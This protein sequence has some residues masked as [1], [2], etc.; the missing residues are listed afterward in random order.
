MTD[1][2]MGLARDPRRSLEKFEDEALNFW[3]EKELR[4]STPDDQSRLWDLP[5]AQSI[6]AK[7]R[8]YGGWDYPSKDFGGKSWGSD[9]RLLETFRQLRI[10]VEVYGFDKRHPAMDAIVDFVG[11]FQSKAGDI[12]GILGNQYMPYYQGAITELLIK[13]G[14]KEDSRIQASL[15]WMLS[16]RQEDGGWIVPIQAIPP[17]RRTDELWSGKPVEPDRSRPSSHMATGMVL[18]AFAAI[19]ELVQSYNVDS[20]IH[21]LV[22]RFFQSDKYNDR[23][24]KDYWLKF[25]FPF[26]WTDLVSA[27]DSASRS[28]LTL[29]NNYLM[30]GQ[31]WFM[32]NQADDGLWDTGYGKGRRSDAN[33]AWVGL[34]I[35]RNILRLTGMN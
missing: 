19:N 18:R 13:A 17:A 21:L 26:W 25:Q 30:Q 14:Y 29:E 12:R 33:R 22:S 1:G 7:Q 6:L 34:A 20:A 35:C 32:D 4:Q 10:L 27:I 24:H 31:Q 2:W 23:R 16:M 8:Q 3:V 5:D 15:A 11:G 9:Y 28:G